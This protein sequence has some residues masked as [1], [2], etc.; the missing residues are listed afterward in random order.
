MMHGNRFLICTLAGLAGALPLGLLAQLAPPTITVVATFDYPGTGNSTT[1]Y[2]INNRGDIAG[3]YL[4]ASNVRRGF[5]RFSNGQFSAPIVEPNDTA[6]YTRGRGINN[7]RTIDGDFFNTADNSY[8]GYILSGG[9][10]TQFD[11]SAGLSTDLYG[12]NDMGNFVGAYGSTT[13]PNQAFVNIA[14]TTTVITIAGAYDAGADTINNANQVVGTYS[15]NSGLVFHGFFRN[16][17]GAL[18]FPLD[19]PGATSTS[20][21]GLSDRGLIVGHYDFADNVDH[22]YLLKLPSTFISFDYPGATATSLNG[23]NKNGLIAGRYTDAGGLRHGF[24]AQVSH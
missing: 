20:A 2:G 12:I 18:T 3:D 1:A 17:N 6:N 22:G 9:V 14:G 21:I 13:Q 11:I 23:I 4:N 24:L 8:H 19:F 7:A 10:F 15:T 5:V 16:A